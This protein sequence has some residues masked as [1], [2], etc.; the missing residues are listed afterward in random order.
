MILSLDVCY[1]H[2]SDFEPT[3]FAKLRLLPANIIGAA[4]LINDL[5]LSRTAMQ[6][7]HQYADQARGV[8]YHR[9]NHPDA[10]TIKRNIR[11]AC[12]REI[13]S[14]RKEAKYVVDVGMPGVPAQTVVFQ[15]CSRRGV[16]MC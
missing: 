15:V 14:G 6:K 16:C 12:T 7:I 3:A 11:H 4:L 10:Q 2:A 5:N 8:P 1:T 13:G 9:R